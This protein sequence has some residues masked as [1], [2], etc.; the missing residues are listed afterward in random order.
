[1]DGNFKNALKVF[2]LV[3]FAGFTLVLLCKIY[4]LQKQEINTTNANTVNNEIMYFNKNNTNKNTQVENTPVIID[5]NSNSQVIIPTVEENTQEN[6]NKLQKNEQGTT[7]INNRYYYYQLDNYAKM[8]YDSILDSIDN[9]KS[10]DYRIDI[11]G[12]FDSLLSRENGQNELNK[13]YDEAVNAI[14]LDIPN[15]FYID[16]S[17]MYLNI[18]TKTSFFTKRNKL[19]IDCGN[20]PNYFSS[21]FNS[22]MQVRIAEGR[23]ETVKSQIIKDIKNDSDY[24]KIKKVHDYLIENIEYDS[25]NT[26]R[27]TIYGALIE[28]KCVCEGYARSFKYI[29]NELGIN[30]ILVVGVGRNSSGNT[31][32]HIWN[33]VELDGK[34]YAVDVTWDDPIVYG[35]GKIGDE[36]K[37]KY[38]LLGEIEFSKNHVANQTISQGGKNIVLPTLNDGNY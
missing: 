16:F 23:I 34:W 29:L 25:N 10:G 32:S 22:S 12:D 11:E 27:N 26:N 18:E 37:H 17:K 13:A 24:D 15:L 35:E 30:N 19:Y 2:L 38:L 3:V 20:E 6:E 21:S 5:D 7:I 14:N 36:I 8:I 1:M 28:R 31:E 9:L 4:D 33:Y